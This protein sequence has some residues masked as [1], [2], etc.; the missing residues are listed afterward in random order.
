MRIAPKPL[1]SYPW[2]LKPFFWNQRR[3][4]GDVLDPALAWGRAPRLFMGVAVLYGMI[5]RKGSP[6]DPPLR[7][8]VTVRV[9]QL[10]HCAF[11][12]DLNSSTLMKRGV[13]MEKVEALPRWRE[14]DLFD[15][16]ERAALDYAEAV[17]LSDRETTDA[18]FAALRQ[19]FDEDAIVEL[20]GLIAFQN[21]SSKFNAALDIP[22][23]GFCALPEAGSDL[24][25]GK[26]EK[27]KG[28]PG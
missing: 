25:E 13:E 1:K 11:C 20:T 19:H 21:L 5:D 17:T 22:P 3:K 8:L 27:E 2:Y 23:Q 10:N 7:S 4:Y 26:E 12:V 14:S 28:E 15:D 24:A 6:I 9:S 18:Q 16:R